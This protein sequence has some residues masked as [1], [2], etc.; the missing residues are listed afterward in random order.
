[1]PGNYTLAVGAFGYKNRSLPLDVKEAKVYDLGDVYLV[2]SITQLKAVTIVA[3]K[4]IIESDAEKLIYN[5]E[6]DPGA[7]GSNAIELLRR[8]PFVTVDGNDNIQLNG[9]GNFKV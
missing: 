1:T 5:A 3:N 2:S 8:T 9:Q 6:N 4:P 7:K